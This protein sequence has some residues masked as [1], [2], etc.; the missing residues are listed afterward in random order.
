MTADANLVFIQMAILV[1]LAVFTADAAG[2]TGPAFAFVYAAFLAVM[3]WQWN[4]GPAAGPPR[5][6]GGDRPVRVGHGRVGRRDP[7]ERVPPAGAATRRL[8]SD[9]RRVGRGDLLAGRSAVGL[10]PGVMPTESLV[11]RFGLFT[12]IVLGEVVFG[13]V[14]GLSLAEHDVT[15]IATGMLAL[16]LG[17]GFWW[18]YFD[19]VGRRLP[20]SDGRSLANWMLSHLPITLS[21]AAAGA[22]MTSLIVHAH[23]AITPG[24]TAWLLSGSV[25]LGLLALI[26]IERALA[27]ADAWRRLPTSAPGDRR[28]SGRGARRRLAATRPVAPRAPAGG[29]P[30][31]PVVLRGV[32]L[33]WGGRVGRGVARD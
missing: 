30:V 12:I 22:G 28:G 11:E 9:Y 24:G 27:D 32:P 33:P 7:R 15:T 5:I 31:G 29:D 19:V 20:R 23:D 2:D 26:V 25:A 6:H 18:I 10:S 21:I 3:T 14:D 4:D 1:L 17:F 13:V 16:G 8:G